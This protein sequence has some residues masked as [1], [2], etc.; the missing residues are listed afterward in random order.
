[1]STGKVADISKELS[2]SFFS[3]QIVVEDP[4]TPT[5]SKGHEIHAPT[6]TRFQIPKQSSLGRT[7]NLAV[8]K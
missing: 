4:N 8:H 6:S 1:V 3:F 2:A 5:A 7:S